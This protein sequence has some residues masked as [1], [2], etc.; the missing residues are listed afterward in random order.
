MD[1]SR[2]KFRAW[3]NKRKRMIVISCPQAWL[4]DGH[5]VMQ[6]TGQ[7]DKAGTL[8]FEGSIV[9]ANYFDNVQ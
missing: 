6:S 7:K 9:K 4:D 1:D 5:K 3:H 8:I 2:F